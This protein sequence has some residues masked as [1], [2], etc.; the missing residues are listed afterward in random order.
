MNIQRGFTL[1]EMIVVIVITGII[2][3]IV[4]IFIQAPVQGYVDS[5]RRAE[6]TDIADTALRRMARDVRIAVPNS[7]RTAACPGNCFE[8]VMT[9]TGGRYRNDLPG[10][11]LVFDGADTTFDILHGPNGTAVAV[12]DVMV[13]GSSQS[14]GTAVYDLSAVR[15]VSTYVNPLI[16]LDL[17]LAPVRQMPTHRFDIVD[18]AVIY[19]CSGVGLD[20]NGNGTG[21]LIRYSGYWDFTASRAVFS[22]P[23]TGGNVLAERVSACTIDYDL[24]N[25][26]FGSF[27]LLSVRLTLTEANESVTL[28]SQMHVNNIP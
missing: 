24:T 15:T 4:A 2:A 27:S 8:F 12:G 23:L 22:V 10:N 6:L 14:G 18:T 26:S 11:T 25:P 28:H 7:V 9:R 21:R 5:S 19:D 13:I 1:I 16:T 20:A 3:G 17:G